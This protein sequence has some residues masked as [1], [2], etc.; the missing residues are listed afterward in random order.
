MKQNCALINLTI[1]NCNIFLYDAFSL[2][3]IFNIALYFSSFIS[4]NFLPNP[5]IF[6][7]NNIY[8]CVLLS[9]YTIANIDEKVKEHKLEKV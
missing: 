7:P 1:V 9:I 2:C 6:I 4:L 8:M 5:Y 3:S